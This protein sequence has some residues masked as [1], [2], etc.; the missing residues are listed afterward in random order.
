MSSAR[1]VAASKGEIKYIG[2]PCR[3]CGLTEKYTRNATCV[4]C[5]CEKAKF[6]VLEQRK[7]IKDLLNQSK[8]GG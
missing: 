2:S 7:K 4:K 6:Y 1:M 3:K 5:S 8:M